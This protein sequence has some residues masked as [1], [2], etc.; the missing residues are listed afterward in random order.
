MN[1][2]SYRSVS[3]LIVSA[4]IFSTLTFLTSCSSSSSSS[5]P[6]AKVVAIAATSG[7]GQSA[8]VGAAFANPLVATVTTGGTPTSGVSVTFTAPAAEPNGTFAGAVATDTETTNASGVA[9]TS[10]A[11]TAGTTAGTYNVTATVAGASTPA[12]FGLTNTAGAATAIAVSSGNNQ[13]AV[14]STAFA[15]PLA[16]LVKD[17]DGNPVAGV[18]VTF[19][20]TAGG[21]GASGAFATSGATDTETTGAN[22]IATTS[23]ALTAN[24]TIGAFTVTADF[25]GDT[26]TPASFA[27]TNT[28]V[29]AAPPL[30]AGNYVYYVAGE[31]NNPLDASPYFVAGVF[32]VS[33][34]GAVTGGEQSFSDDFNFFPDNIVGATSSVVAG[35]NGNVLITLDTGDANIGVAGVETFDASLVTSSNGL[36][37][38]Y[39]SWASGSGSLDLQTSAAAPSGGYAFFNGG[40]DINGDAIVIGGV[41]NV[42]S[43]T[44]AGSV[45]DENDGGTTSADQ[46][47]SATTVK[48]PDTFGSVTF[49]LTPA[50]TSSTVAEF[51][52]VGYIVD[53]NHIKWVENWNVDDLEANAGGVALG[54]GANVG[55][56]SSSNLSASSGVFGAV[57]ADV[58]G[59]FQI[60]GLLTFNADLSLGGVISYNDLVATSTPGGAALTGGAWAIDASGTGNDGGTGRV[61]ISNVSDGVNTFTFQLYL[62]KDGGTLISMDA[63]HWVTGLGYGQA[64][65]GAF[66]A[67]SFS[68]N[69]AL[70]VDQQDT[71]STGGFEYDG[72]GAVNANGTSAFTGFLDLNGILDAP[73]TPTAGATGGVT[74]TFPTTNANGVFSGTITGVDTVTAGTADTF[75]FYLIG[76]PSGASVGVIGIEDDGEQLT[77]A[78]FEL[79][80]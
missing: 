72:V 76:A 3:A 42:N 78:T 18:T 16:A 58:N 45:F 9:T 6:P 15:N 47:F 73:L 54:Q 57:G 71:D 53:A 11:F 60:G 55:T 32:T 2:K 41:V 68:G 44:G 49:T 59:P 25:T 67:A 10:L 21:G 30:G 4:L 1:L 46:L 12:T 50:V 62:A 63:N 66:T 7:G 27:L 77:L 8:Q 23:Q 19:T 48:A 64:G 37:I 69:Y 26:G 28:A 43:A 74:G 34:S 65:S 20:I 31:D 29:A 80:Q 24:A 36:L 61:T 70:N 75:T 33:A 39:D 79:L 13:S 22:G 17:G 14:V 38:E 35:N 40:V 51:T 56:Y 5:T 52:M